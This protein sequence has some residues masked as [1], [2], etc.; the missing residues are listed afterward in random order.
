MKKKIEQNIK[1][2]KKNIEIIKKNGFKIGVIW[3]CSIR[4]ETIF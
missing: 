3:D 2:D 1:R 4:N